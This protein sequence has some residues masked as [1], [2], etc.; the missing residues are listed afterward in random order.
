[1]TRHFL[2]A[3]F[4]GLRTH[5]II[6]IAGGAALGLGV[7]G[8][9]M[10]ATYDGLGPFLVSIL[11]AVGLLSMALGVVIGGRRAGSD[12]RPENPSRALFASGC[13][14][15]IVPWIR[16]PLLAALD[17]L[18][19]RAAVAF[20][21]V[22][23]LAPAW[24]PIGTVVPAAIRLGAA[25]GG[26]PF[27]AAARAQAVFLVAG[28]VAALLAIWVLLPGL[29]VTR[30]ALLLGLVLVMGGMLAA[31]APSRGATTM[32][33]GLL[34]LLAVAFARSPSRAGTDSVVRHVERGVAR[35]VRVLEKEGARYLLADGTIH[36]VATPGSFVSLH[37]A[38]AALEIV[39]RLRPTPGSA[40]VI[41][42]RG[43]SLAKTLARDGWRVSAIEPDPALA[44]AAGDFFG[45]S[46]RECPV[47]V[48]GARERLRHDR[49]AYDL[50]VLDA[51]GDNLVPVELVTRE[52][53]AVADSRLAPGG[54]LAVAFEAQGWDDV[55]VRSLAATL[56]TR[57]ATVIA[58]PTGEPPNT[59]GSVVLLAAHGPIDFTG[60]LPEPHDYLNAPLDHWTVVQMNHAWTSGFAPDP[61]GAV[62]LTDDR[63]PADLWGD[64]INQAARAELHG[65]FGRGEGW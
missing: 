31:P 16:A 61:R 34:A 10:L 40:L 53:F 46:A 59:L 14:V 56:R 11:L 44:R 18:G 13:W 22:V 54:L 19:P 63:N 5:L 33:A 20:A 65:F 43:G 32:G 39:K 26:S 62:V 25:A 9:R 60:D 64:R 29:G 37:R 35:E 57:F 58:L 51:F 50:V 47:I 48:R 36:A 17:P 42:L 12:P 1:M 27:R 28:L 30:T 55:L 24:V 2:R 49:T 52:F 38:V 23:L 8:A 6:A 7:V 41:G 45:L 15:A 4:S 21:A 3:S